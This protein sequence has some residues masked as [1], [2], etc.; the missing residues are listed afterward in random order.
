MKAIQEICN[1]LAG[2]LQAAIMEK[3]GAFDASSPATS[4]IS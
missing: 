4:G 1:A 3:A 2:F